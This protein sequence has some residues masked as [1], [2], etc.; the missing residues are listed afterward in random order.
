MSTLNTIFKKIVRKTGKMSWIAKVENRCLHNVYTLL[1]VS[2]CLRNDKTHVYFDSIDDVRGFLRIGVLHEPIKLLVF[3]IPFDRVEQCAFQLE[4]A[5]EHGRFPANLVPG[6][7]SFHRQPVTCKTAAYSGLV[8]PNIVCSRKS[9]QLDFA[10]F[11][12]LDDY[13]VLKKTR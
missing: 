5:P 3:S 4:I 8:R 10:V 7:H 6:Y 1:H 12:R 11:T 9:E 2:N 13:S